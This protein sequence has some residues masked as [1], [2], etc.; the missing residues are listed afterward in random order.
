MRRHERPTAAA[1]ALAMLLALSLTGSG[2]TAQSPDDPAV[3]FVLTPSRLEIRAQPGERQQMAVTVYNRADEPLLLDAY[4]EDIDFPRSELIQPDDLAFTASRWLSF[5]T[6]HL[7]I[8]G[9]ADANIT[10]TADVP[11]ATPTGGYHALGFLQSRPPVG[12]TEI[13]PSGRIGVTLLLEVS[14]EDAELNRSARVSESDLDVRWNNPFDPE[15]IARTIVDNTGEAHVV[16]G[17]VHTF[18]GWP[19]AGNSEAKIGPHT[20]LRGTRHTFESTWDAVPL[21]GKVTVTSEI[22][23]QVGPDDLPV[24]VSQH[25]VWIIPWHLF[26]ALGVGLVLTYLVLKRRKLNKPLALQIAENQS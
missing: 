13:Q 22:V 3:D 4:I 26:G 14:P 12:S 16:A 19:G 17:G 5:G 20:A 23:Y 9:G 7:E 25:T 6:D 24:I 18:R 2:V 15:V 21:F 10:I 1:A 11:A 8:A